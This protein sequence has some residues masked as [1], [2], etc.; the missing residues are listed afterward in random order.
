MVIRTETTSSKETEGPAILKRMRKWLY[1][2]N[3][4]FLMEHIFV[5][6]GYGKTMGNGEIGAVIFWNLIVNY[7]GFYAWYYIKI[8]L[9]SIANDDTT[10]EKKTNTKCPF[11][12]LIFLE[13]LM[14]LNCTFFGIRGLIDNISV[15]DYHKTYGGE[16]RYMC[17]IFGN[18]SV[19]LSLPIIGY[20]IYLSYIWYKYTKNETV[21]IDHKT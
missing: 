5:I 18:S 6:I 17:A 12:A 19:L 21:Q 4:W 16:W 13:I 7:Y 2:M 20:L 3:A 11:Y 1:I 14:I 9:K 8:D 15:D 10:A